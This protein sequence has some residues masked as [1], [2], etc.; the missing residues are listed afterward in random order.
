MSA[1]K[2]LSGLD[3]VALDNVL[4]AYTQAPLKAQLLAAGASGTVYALV[5]PE[6]EAAL[7]AVVDGCDRRLLL[8]DPDALDAARRERWFAL[9]RAPWTQRQDSMHERYFDR[10]LEW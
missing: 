4:P 7:A 5:M 3:R 1:D 9:Y 10:W 8:Y 6:G 2:P